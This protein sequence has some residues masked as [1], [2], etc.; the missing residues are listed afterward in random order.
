MV[1]ELYFNKATL[2]KRQ[3]SNFLGGPVVKNP[4]CN[5]EEPSSIA[6]R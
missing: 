4:S 1:Y 2:N 6:G 5:E 3:F